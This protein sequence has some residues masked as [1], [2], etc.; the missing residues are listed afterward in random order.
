MSHIVFCWELGLGSGHVLGFLPVAHELKMRGHEVTFIFKDISRAEAML[1]QHDFRYL[2]APLLLV[3]PAIKAPILSYADILAR[4]A[5]LDQPHLQSL[6][7]AWR[8]LF[9]VLKPDLLIMDHAPT[10]LLAAKGLGVPRALLG[11]GFFTPPQSNPIPSFRS[12]QS[13]DEQALINSE[14]NV[15]S[16]INKVLEKLNNTE[17]LRQFSDLFQVEENFLCTFKELD[18]YPSRGE[19]QYWGPRFSLTEGSDPD[20]PMGKGKRVFVYMYMQYHGFETV[21]KS[22]NAFDIS[23]IVYVPGISQQ[24]INRFQSAK[25]A[26]VASPINMQKVRQECDIC[27]CHAGHGTVSAMLLAGKPLVMFPMHAEQTIVARNV[28][29]M[30]AGLFVDMNTKNV[31]SKKPLKRLLQEQ[32]FTEKAREFANTYRD[33]S[34]EIQTQKISDC[35]ELLTG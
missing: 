17:K 26:L 2:Q 6:V 20:W 8:N 28:E 35:C 29:Q 3:K 7:S 25:V 24:L 1:G 34:H 14:R 13:V 22:F 11:T 19:S 10:A 32:I 30:G 15:L 12:W 18:H 31:N 27:I 16:V 33:F 23:V 4:Y 21:I 9:K 5:Y